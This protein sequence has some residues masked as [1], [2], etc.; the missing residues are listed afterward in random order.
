MLLSPLYWSLLT[1]AFGH[2]VW[3]LIRDPFTWD[4]TPHRASR[5]MKVP[6]AVMSAEPEP[7]GREAA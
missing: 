2:A 6:V 7:A 3:R 5:S 1:L 4:K